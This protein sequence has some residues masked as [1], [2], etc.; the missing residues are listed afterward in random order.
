MRRKQVEKAANHERWLLTYADMITLLMIFFIVL[1]AMS[2]ADTERFRLVSA[3]LQRAFAV[4]VYESPVEASATGA[5]AFDARIAAFVSL[6][7]QVSA[8]AEDHNILDDVQIHLVREGVV[9]SLSGNF[10]FESGR[11]EVR[12]EAYAVLDTVSKVLHDLPNEV[13]VAGHTDN[14]PIETPLYASNWELSTA[15][16]VAIVK[17]LVA[18]GIEPERLAATGFG[19]FRPAAPNDSRTSRAKNRRAELLVVF[20]EGPPNDFLTDPATEGGP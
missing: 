4:T 17:Y 13:R 14:V 2:K 10:L 7:G 5:A 12:P 20:P 8:V 11:A 15:R 9:V 16:A 19:E 18:T 3:S 1:Y 6:R